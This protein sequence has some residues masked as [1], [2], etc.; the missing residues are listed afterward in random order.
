MKICQYEE[1]TYL[2]GYFV[3]HLVGEGNGQSL[4]RGKTISAN[5]QL[6]TQIFL[7]SVIGSIKVLRHHDLGSQ[8]SEQKC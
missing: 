5:I 3:P 4:A 2:L 7:S 1:L 6:L 8:E